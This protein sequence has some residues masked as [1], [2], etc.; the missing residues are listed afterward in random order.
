MPSQSIEPPPELNLGEC[1]EWQLI[2][3]PYDPSSWS[4][5]GGETTSIGSFKSNQGYTF[6]EGAPLPDKLN[7]LLSNVIGIITLV[8]GLAFLFYFLIGAINWITSAGDSQKAL[9]ARQMI[10]NAV[11]GILI[12]VAA[13]PIAALLGK[14]LNIPLADPAGL[15]NSFFK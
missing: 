2:G 8:A 12:T 13:Y 11:I 5:P 4:C 1:Q 15:I 7:S 3:D 6:A 14:I 10:I 9:K